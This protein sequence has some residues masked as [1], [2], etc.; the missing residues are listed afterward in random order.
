MAKCWELRGCD[1]E[2]MSECPHNEPGERCPSR[3]AFAKC[4]RPMHAVA[5]D[6]A[7]VFDPWADRKEA[8]REECTYCVFFLEKGPRI[9]NH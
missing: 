1:D 9:G 8:I 5:S 6:A 3:C 2:M 4:D 7:L